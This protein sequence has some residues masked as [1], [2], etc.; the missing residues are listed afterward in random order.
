MSDTRWLS[1]ELAVT[2]VVDQWEELKLHFALAETKEKCHKASILHQLFKD[3]K[4]LL[5]LLFL[6]PVLSNLQ[7][8]NKCFQSNN[9]NS[10]ELLK[11]LLLAINSLKIG[12]IPPHVEIDILTTDD[13]EKFVDIDLY[14][15]YEFEK[16]LKSLSVDKNFENELRNSCTTF[17]IELI[18]Q[19]KQR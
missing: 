7:K 15:G 5:Y 6:K 8:V 3:E 1:I 10:T 14:K 9:T 12:I 18:K 17:L 4:N 16:R 13:F 19:L 2:R 11:D